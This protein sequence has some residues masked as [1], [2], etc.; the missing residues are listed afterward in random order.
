LTIEEQI[1]EERAKLQ[2]DGLHPVTKESF[3]EWKRLKAEKK[4]TELENKFKEEQKKS[5][6]GNTVM[7]G[8][9]LF[10]YDATLFQDDEDAADDK[11]Y[12]E[13]IEEAEETKEEDEKFVLNSANDD[14]EYDKNNAAA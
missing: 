14:A 11:F 4:Q 12:D 9:A 2:S 10:K 1:E 13:I 7:S 3:M 6:K 8:K 5:T